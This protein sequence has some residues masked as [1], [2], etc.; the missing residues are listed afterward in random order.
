[1]PSVFELD[2]APGILLPG[3]VAFL[4]FGIWIVQQSDG[5]WSSSSPQ[6]RLTLKSY[7]VV[8][9]T[10]VHASGKRGFMNN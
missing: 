10:L 1:M 6:R 3:T 7:S 2:I 5:H 9:F 4:L 8:I